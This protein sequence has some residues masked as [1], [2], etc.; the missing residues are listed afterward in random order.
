VQDLLTPLQRRIGAGGHLNRRTAEDIE[1]VG[2]AIVELEQ[3]PLPL[4]PLLIGVAR[5]GI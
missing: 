5:P 4:T 3:R 2:L 1:T